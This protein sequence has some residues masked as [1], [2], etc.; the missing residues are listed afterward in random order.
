MPESAQTLVSLNQI[1]KSFKKSERQDL[2][3]LDSVNFEIV[4]GEIIA[5]LGKSGSGKSTLLRIIAGLASATSGQAYYRG[6]LIDGPV[7]GV[8][9]VFQNFALLPWLTVLGNVELGLEA[10][11]LSKHECRARALK[12]IDMIGL[13][14]FE[15]AY[16]KELSGGMR[17]RVGIARALVVEPDLLLMDEAFS[18]L[19]VLTAENLKTDLLDLWN[20]KQTK[21]KG[22]L[23]VTHSI[24]E[25]LM[26]ADRVVLF[27][28][29][30][31]HIRAEKRVNIP[32]P[33]RSDDPVF[34]ELMDEIYQLMVNPTQTSQIS[35]RTT[36]NEIGL[37]YRL[38]NIEL[39][40]LTGL[41]EEISFEE[42]PEG[43]EFSEVAESLHLDVDDLL[44][45]LEILDILRFAR[46]SNGRIIPTKSGLFFADADILEKKQIF[47]KHLIQH[48]PLAK[49]IRRVLDERPGHKASKA[50]F[51]SELEDHLSEDE[52]ERVLKTI[53]DWGRYAEII[54]YD[55][56][57]EILSLEN[58]H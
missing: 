40:E 32:R 8:S 46:L 27:G 14:G 12:T 47:A 54:A 51:L 55:S 21:I 4:E 17:Q 49:H 37:G 56:D 30:P 22:I 24:E 44:P 29:D 16:P 23:L 43:L 10:L 6:Q 11:G 53:I 25:A 28:S 33:R 18:A 39:S 3:V 41:I 52:A 9:M 5:I 7:R 19:D 31:G 57:T 34:H 42:K 20:E 50:R 13:D 58:P 45:L 1:K 2:L 36:H 35:N 26:M 48:V 38:P 15:S